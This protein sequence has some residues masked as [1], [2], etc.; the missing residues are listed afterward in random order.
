MAHV[1]THAHAAFPPPSM[2]TDTRTCTHAHLQATS[3]QASTSRGYSPFGASEDTSA[4]QERLEV[5]QRKLDSMTYELERGERMLPG[6]G[7]RVQ[8]APGHACASREGMCVPWRTYAGGRAGPLTASAIDCR[9]HWMQVPFNA[10][11]RSCIG[12]VKSRR[13]RV[14]SGMACVVC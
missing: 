9:C 11:V 1:S 7:E 8:N 12:I 3:S 10:S 14:C 13:A 6:W 5:L 4:A 2:H